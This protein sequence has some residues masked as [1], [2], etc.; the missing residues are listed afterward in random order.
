MLGV[1]GWYITSVLFGVKVVEYV[2][3]V[4]VFVVELPSYLCNVEVKS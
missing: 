1:V 2:K 3:D 4:S